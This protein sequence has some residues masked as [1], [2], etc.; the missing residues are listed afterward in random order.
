MT[1]LEDIESTFLSLGLN[2]QV[3]LEE[4]VAS[5][6]NCQAIRALRRIKEFIQNRPLVSLFLVVFIVLGFLPFVVFA[7]FVSSSFLVVAMSAIMVFGGTF[8]VAFASFLVVMFPLLMLGSGLAGLAYLTY[9]AVTRILQLVNRLR[10]MVKSFPHFKRV[11][12]PSVRID[13]SLN[14]QITMPLYLQP[15]R[16]CSTDEQL[17][18]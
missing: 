4:R 18:N 10:S 11:Y 12:K 17:N 3:P 7:A 6:K 14:A 9:C 15:T 5:L 2:L 13:A 8:A 1:G 16:N